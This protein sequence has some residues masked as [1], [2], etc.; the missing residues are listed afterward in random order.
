MNHYIILVVGVLSY[1]Y[2]SGLIPIKVLQY[3]TPDFFFPLV[4][5]AVSILLLQKRL[6]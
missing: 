1:Y 2:F 3:H 5:V 6:T 4:P